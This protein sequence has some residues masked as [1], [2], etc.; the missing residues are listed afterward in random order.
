MN[1]RIMHP[2]LFTFLINYIAYPFDLDPSRRSIVVGSKTT[3][4]FLFE[5][6]DP[7][8]FGQ[9]AI[10]YLPENDQDHTF[11]YLHT[12]SGASFAN[13]FS[14]LVWKRANDTRL[15]KEGKQ[16]MDGA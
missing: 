11:V 5:G 14:E 2:L 13:S 10:L 3:L 8:L 15:S 9:K 12:A 4:N 7:S 6:I 1:N 16:L